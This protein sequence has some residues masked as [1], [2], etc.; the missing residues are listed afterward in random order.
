MAF[1]FGGSRNVKRFTETTKWDD[2]W[3]IR[4]SP[5]DKLLW[6]YICDKCD[7]A[8]VIDFCTE[9]ASVV[10]GKQLSEDGLNVFGQRVK[11]LETGKWQIVKFLPFQ[12]RTVDAN[13]PAHKP[14]IECIKRNGL[15]YPIANQDSL[16]GRLSHSL[17]DRAKEKEK[18]KSARA[19]VGKAIPHDDLWL[20]T[21]SQDPT[22]NGIDVAREH[23]KMLRWCES[24]GK[25]PTRR[26]FINWLNRAEKPM[27]VTATT[28]AGVS[29]VD[30]SGR[31]KSPQQIEREEKRDREM[32]EAKENYDKTRTN[33]EDHAAVQ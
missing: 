15:D 18:E 16:R 33:R 1:E 21:L 13:C 12:Y 8:G 26:R 25:L 7:C 4:L 6:L 3:F 20:K 30:E 22:Y 14:V 9:I 29:P 10:I 28:T 5:H 17:Q 2:P 19:R 23:G 11:Q 31:R 32:R 24:N 27:L